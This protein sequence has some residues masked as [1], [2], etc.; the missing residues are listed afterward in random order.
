M[1]NKCK[2][3]QD[4]GG[5]GAKQGQGACSHGGNQLRTPL[6]SQRGAGA[7]HSLDAV[8]RGNSQCVAKPAGSAFSIS[9]IS[10]SIPTIFLSIQR[11]PFP[12][13]PCGTQAMA[14]RAVSLD[15]LL[16]QC[17]FPISFL[18]PIPTSLPAHFHQA[19]PINKTHPPLV[20]PMT[21]E[22]LASF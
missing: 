10:L 15:P 20:E 9:G 22:L 18:P 3:Q 13:D 8:S 2:T 5:L 1:A 21:R 6:A 16:S 19:Q 7:C 14:T 11:S 4:Q 17:P 12:W